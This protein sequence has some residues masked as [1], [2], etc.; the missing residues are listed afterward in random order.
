MPST[1]TITGV[2]TTIGT[3]TFTASVVDSGSPSQ[4]A[5]ATTAV[6]VAPAATGPAQPVS[7]LNALAIATSALPSVGV[8]TAYSQTLQ[9]SGGTAPYTWALASG[10]LPAGL[11]ISTAGLISGTPTATGTATFSV[12]VTDSSSPAQTQ[13]AGLTIATGAGALSITSATL[14]S[15]ST[16]TGYAQT[17]AATGGTPA[18]TWQITSGSLPAGLT[19]AAT[20]GVISGTPTTNGT[21]TFTAVVQDNGSP[22]QTQSA[23]TSIT[24]AAAQT[25][26]GPGATWYVNAAGGSRYSVNSTTGLC[27]GTSAAAPVGTTPNQH[28]AFNDVRYLWTDG[29]YNTDTGAGAPKWG[30]I[31]HGGDTYLIDCSGMTGGACRV[32][33]NG[34]NPGDGFGLAGNP[35][36]S[37][38]PVPLSGSPTAHT[39]IFG[40]NHGACSAQSARTQIY[41]GYG[42]GTVL[43]MNGASYVDIAC[44]DITDHSSCGRQG[45][46]NTC[47]SNYPVGDFA[48]D[49]IGWSNTSTNDTLTDV[50]IHGMSRTGM[51]GPT[52]TGVVMTDIAIIGNA[53][54]G[55]NADNASGT[56][57]TGTLLVQNFNISWNGCAEEYP[58]VDALPYSDCTDDNAGGYGDGFG[59][60]TTASVPGWQAHFDQGVVSYNTQDGLDALHLTG[61][62]SSMTITRVLAYGNMGQQIKV[63]GASGTAVNNLLVT[64]CNALR[65]VIPGTPAGYN[66]RLSDFCRAADTGI[67]MTVGKG[68]TL[69]F[70]NNTVYAAN[71]TAMEI[72]CDGSAG[73]CDSTSLIDFR[74]NIF[75]GFINGP[76]SGYPGM[77]TGDYSNPIYA[78]TVNPFPNPGSIFANNLTYHPKS[79]WGCP[80]TYYFEVNAI[81]A[82]PH[83]VDETWH[84]YGYGNMSPAPGSVL[85]GAGA[86]IQGITS[87]YTGA[88]RTTTPT[89][90][91]YE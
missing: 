67:E 48:T 32:G 24:I 59:T 75:L 46:L 56:T 35:S 8:G 91:A 52:G 87:D 68:S 6:V 90:G 61:S 44:L 73:P 45:Q 14:S 84:L 47:N 29:S 50:R 39:Q 21:S 37:G 13:S 77:T 62:G 42:T 66:S 30:W 1:G 34:P 2:P 40:I 41:G 51:I 78:A 65:N 10:Q 70:D 72:D 17:L 69:T 38:A 16:G 5:S 43:S 7:P 88:V 22:A 18:Y 58:I 57:G 9:A 3:A 71:G 49:G 15:G 55:W 26:S 19:L 23:T 54:S 79:S 36:G 12:S 53:S 60:A 11:S 25:S 4:L 74:N 85:K 89:I 82:D 76:S 31:G 81:C 33:Q 28:C 27:D 86:L 64:N 80:A 20:T 63:G 83:L